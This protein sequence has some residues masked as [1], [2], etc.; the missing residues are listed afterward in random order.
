MK[1]ERPEKYFQTKYD[2]T[3][4]RRFNEENYDEKEAEA[5]PASVLEGSSDGAED[6]QRSN[7]RAKMGSRQRRGA[8]ERPGTGGR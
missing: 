2:F 7:H 4:S 8:R 6:E 1:L 3:S 5:E